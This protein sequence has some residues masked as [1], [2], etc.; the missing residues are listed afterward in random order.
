[1]ANKFRGKIKVFFGNLR[2][3]IRSIKLPKL[4]LSKNGLSG[5]P[6]W[7]FFVI[8]LLVIYVLG[9]VVF[10]VLTY[11]KCSDTVKK[12]YRETK[13]VKFS[14]RIYP[15]PVVWVG[16]SPIWAVN[17]NKQLNYITRFSSK[18]GQELPNKNDLRNQIID[19]MSQVVIL[20][21]QAKKNKIK[22]TTTDISEAYKKIIDQ[23]GG[24]EEVKKVL[25][26]LYGMSE[27]D[28]KNLI[29]DQV[30]KEKI[31]SDLL[32]QIHAE[33][34]LIKDENQ[35]KD[36][37]AQVK[38]GEKSF[39]DLAKQ[40]SEDTGSKDSGGDLGWFGRG[41]MV[42][43]FEDAAFVLQKDQVSELVKSEFGYH[44]IKI[45][46]RKGTVDKGFD[47]W[48]AEILAKTKIR[49]WLN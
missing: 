16:Y 47:T 2:G 5:R 7:L 9:G 28:F 31:Q 8:V 35:A 23:N 15:F 11:K 22:V 10:G 26:D 6:V 17:Y 30:Y 29:G 36:V 37:L 20:K 48:Y 45:I 38:K 24:A 1:M 25:A 39:E 4:N 43:E 49:K 12:C 18:S 40:Y 33:H 41:T 34:I 19:Q 14:A 46:D 27:K 3:K 42:K 21:Q 44:I 32:V 13:A